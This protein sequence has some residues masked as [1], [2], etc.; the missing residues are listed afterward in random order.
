[1]RRYSHLSVMPR[2]RED[3]RPA[4]EEIRTPTR[5]PDLAGDVLVPLLQAGITGL[6]FAAGV[7]AVAAGSGYD[8]DLLA[9]GAGV[10]L[11]VGI[12][13][14]LILLVDTRSLL[15]IVERLAHRDLDGDGQVGR[16]PTVERTVYLRARAIPPAGA[17][18][19]EGT[20]LAQF[21]RFVARRGTDSRQIERKFGRARAV[22]L[23][24]ALIANG[25]A[26]WRG[27]ERRSGWD[28]V[29]EADE[30]VANIY[31]S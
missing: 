14:W 1:M 31:Q 3:P 18:A 19:G 23:R 2:A 8:G 11:S 25:W 22:A 17:G 29:A 7:V 21:V 20:Q 10:C 27:D 16:P 12:L 4:P 24:D 5:A 15:R 28:L 13:A 9:L 30:I 26:E 6:L